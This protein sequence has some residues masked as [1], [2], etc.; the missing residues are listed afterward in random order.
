MKFVLE[1]LFWNLFLEFFFW[2]F[3]GKILESFF[4]GKKCPDFLPAGDRMADSLKIHFFEEKRF[5]WCQGLEL[6]TSWF[7]L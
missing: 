7:E 5:S 4:L 3:F 2:N 6:G 1:I